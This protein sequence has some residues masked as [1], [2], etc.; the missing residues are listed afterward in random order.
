MHVCLCFL[1]CFLCQNRTYFYGN[2]QTRMHG[3][4]LSNICHQSICIY[5]LYYF[6]HMNRIQAPYDWACV[7]M[8]VELGLP[9]RGRSTAQI[10]RFID[11]IFRLFDIMPGSSCLV[12][13]VRFYLIFSVTTIVFWKVHFTCII[14]P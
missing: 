9:S 6:T 1:Q 12:F 10:S 13:N 8:G 11:L 14:P 4:V 5:N 7:P 2:T 3:R